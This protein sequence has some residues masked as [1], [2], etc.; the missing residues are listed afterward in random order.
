[1]STEGDFYYDQNSFAEQATSL[2]YGWLAMPHFGGSGMFFT[3]PQPDELKEREELL[4]EP[5]HDFLRENADGDFSVGTVLCNEPGGQERR[6]VT[7]SMHW[8]IR[9]SI[10]DIL[11]GATE[12]IVDTSM[13]AMQPRLPE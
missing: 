10:G 9:K 1:M 4:T 3:F 11:C 7:L 12:V 6:Y 8:P 5:V 13:A 2:P